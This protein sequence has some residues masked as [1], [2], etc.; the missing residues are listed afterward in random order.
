MYFF[1]L[2]IAR[3]DTPQV[4]YT[5]LY[6]WHTARVFTATIW[7]SVKKYSIWDF[8]FLS[9]R[10]LEQ[11]LRVMVKPSGLQPSNVTQGL[12]NTWLGFF[13]F[14]HKFEK[15]KSLEKK[16]MCAFVF[17]T[18]SAKFDPP[19]ILQVMSERRGCLRLRWTL[20]PHQLWLQTSNMIL[21]IR[22]KSVGSPHWND[23]VS[24]NQP[25][26]DMKAIF[27]LPAFDAVAIDFHALTFP[28]W[29]L[30]C[31]CQDLCTICVP[32]TC[33]RSL[34]EMLNHQGLL[35][36]VASCTGLSTLLRFESDTSR[37]PGVNGAAASLVSP[38]RA[39]GP[40]SIQTDTITHSNTFQSI[41]FSSISCSFQYM[42]MSCSASAITFFFY[43]TGCIELCRS[44]SIN[45]SFME[46]FY[47][48][49]RSAG[50]RHATCWQASLSFQLPLDAST[51]GWRC[52]GITCPNN[53]T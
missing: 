7:E 1:S 3:N 10:L 20:S 14:L 28:A 12:V 35:T 51:H 39:V 32:G 52:L 16:I 49:K 31:I 13:F 4:R 17:F 43:S 24:S 36:C 25:C 46:K 47:F 2:N 8:F 29:G 11:S 48:L 34:W 44:E 30:H 18:I 40:R 6:S 41:S 9:F 23:P 50:F 15:L 37:A 26:V 53:S 27:I 42:L 33:V 21:E 22:L 5:Q 19:K 38:W 45:L